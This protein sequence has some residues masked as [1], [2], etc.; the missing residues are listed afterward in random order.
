MIVRTI[1][2]NKDDPDFLIVQRD[3]IHSCSLRRHK[4]RMRKFARQTC[5]DAKITFH[6]FFE[7]NDYDEI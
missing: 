1:I 5:L 3:Q 6:I 7:E 4:D 2:Y